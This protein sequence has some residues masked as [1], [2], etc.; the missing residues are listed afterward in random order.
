MFLLDQAEEVCRKRLLKDPGNREA[1]HSLGK[2]LRKQGKLD[3]A[4]AIYARLAEADPEDREARYLHAI[5]SG[6]DWPPSPT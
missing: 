5:F 1:G 6:I 3:E 2:V 4:A